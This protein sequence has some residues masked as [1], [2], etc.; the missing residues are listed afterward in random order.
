MRIFWFL[1]CVIFLTGCVSYAPHERLIGQ[2][3]EA[4]VQSM[5]A[6]YAEVAERSGSRL[7]YPRGPFGKSTFFIHLDAAG[8]VTR[9]EDV[10]TISNLLQVRP[11]MRASEVEQ[12]IGPSLSR[13]SVAQGKQTIWDYPFPNSVCQIF[14]V[15]MTPEGTV[16][17]AGFGY[18]PECGSS[19]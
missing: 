13:W 5:G 15:A 10:L 14:Q 12:L 4:V 17:S 16:A 18:A 19:W 3:R 9:W 7:V 11:G 1:G 6:P 8:S 2:N